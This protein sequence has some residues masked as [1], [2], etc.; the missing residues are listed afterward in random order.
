MQDLVSFLSELHSAGVDL[1]LDRQGL[2]TTTPAGKAMF[3]MLGVFAEFERGIIKERI[4]VGL[5]RAREPG[6]KSGKPFGRPTIP[7]KTRD[8]ILAART[9][10]LSIR[11]TAR[12][13]GVS[14]GKAHGVIKEAEVDAAN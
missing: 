5:D 4:A 9:S 1:Y 12:A 14:V 11:E 6:T 2:E 3:Q 10:G 13:A 8:A 7:A